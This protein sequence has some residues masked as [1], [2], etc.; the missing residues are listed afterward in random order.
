M[1]QIYNIHNIFSINIVFRVLIYRKYQ[2]TVQPSQIKIYLNSTIYRVAGSE[3]QYIYSIIQ[4]WN[5]IDKE[6]QI[7]NWPS[8]IDKSISDLSVYK[9]R[10]LYRQYKI[11][12]YRQI[13]TIKMYWLKIYRYCIQQDRSRSTSV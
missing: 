12:I 13:G 3:I 9:N 11:Y 1:A 2:Y 4:Q 6:I 8:Q 7:D 5:N 10:L